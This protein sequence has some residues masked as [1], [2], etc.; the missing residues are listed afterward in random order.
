MIW[1]TIPT[2]SNQA[3]DIVLGVKD[4]TTNPDPFIGGPSETPTNSNLLN[5]VSVSSDGVR[6]YGHWLQYNDV[7]TEDAANRVRSFLGRTLGD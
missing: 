7:A 4:F 2:Q 6:L 1:N 3:A 5:P